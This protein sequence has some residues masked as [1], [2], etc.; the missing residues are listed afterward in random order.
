MTTDF[1]N[2]EQ[3][4]RSAGAQ[5]ALAAPQRVVLYILGVTG[6]ALFLAGVWMLLFPVPW[7]KPSVAPMIALAFI[8]SGIGDAC[9]VVFLRWT[10]LRAARRPG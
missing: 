7:F 6:L 5:P 9:A 8:L 3:A 1:R 10:W 2:P 4:L